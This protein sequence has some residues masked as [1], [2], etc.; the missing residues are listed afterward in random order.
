MTAGASPLASPR[1][2][3]GERKVTILGTTFDNLTLAEAADEVENLIAAGASSMVCVKDVALTVRA[4]ES[5]FLTAFYAG[6]E[7]MFVDGRG[8]FYASRLLARPLAE[9]VG[10]PGI[11][12]ELLRRAA[13]KSYRVFIV[14]ST[15]TTL[16]TA[17]ARARVR[18]PDLNIV[19]WRDGYFA[20]EEVDDVLDEIRRAK[21]QL[22]FVG[23][24][25]PKREQFIQRLRDAGIPCVSVAIGGVLD[26]EAGEKRLA[27]TWISHLGLEWFF[28]A[29]Q[30]PRRL[31]PRYLRTHSRFL[32]L[33]A[34]ELIRERFGSAESPKPGSLGSRS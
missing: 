25:T 18:H 13:T 31:F 10:G 1:L 30:E 17:I 12:F 9:V 34:R 28:R 4:S 8:L 5:D 22:V 26:V 15:R 33:V 16:Q 32:L 29:L 2:R 19:G 23:I 20:N 14:G 27:P 11:Y 21:P 3:H 6:A 7:L 24:A